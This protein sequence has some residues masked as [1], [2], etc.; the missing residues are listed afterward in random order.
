M[1]QSANGVKNIL[2]VNDAAMSGHSIEDHLDIVLNAFTSYGLSGVVIGALFYSNY[3]LSKSFDKKL[4]EQS[5]RHQAERDVWLKHL[6][7]F[8]DDVMQILLKKEP[9]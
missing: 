4:T 9:H 1:E 5:E 7:D 8:H 2:Q 6:N 3:V